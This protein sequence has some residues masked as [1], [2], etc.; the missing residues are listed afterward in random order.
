L[1]FQ[2]SFSTFWTIVHSHLALALFSSRP[3]LPTFAF[4]RA[5]SDHPE[6]NDPSGGELQLSTKLRILYGAAKGLAYLHKLRPPVIHRD[7]K[8][9][10][11][12]LDERW[13]AKVTDFGISR[14]KMGAAQAL[15]SFSGTVAWMSPELL[16][17]DK[18][19]NESVDIYSLAMVMFEAMTLETPFDGMHVGQ[20]V[21]LV[22]QQ[23]N[24]PQLWYTVAPAEKKAQELMMRMWAAEVTE[25]PGADEVVTE[26]RSICELASSGR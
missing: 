11:V 21:M 8:A 10:N 6:N 20:L 22:A 9:A 15:T 13:Q 26:L 7:M 2:L 16:R 5:G 4:R 24:R 14:V 3:F 19:Y 23:N 1:L 25:R 17:G 12:L 18:T